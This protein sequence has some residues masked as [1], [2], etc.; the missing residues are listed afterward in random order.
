MGGPCDGGASTNIR[1][2]I[3]RNIHMRCHCTPERPWRNV[4][5]RLLPCAA[6]HISVRGLR[7]TKSHVF[8]QFYHLAFACGRGRF[9]SKRTAPVGLQMFIA[10]GSGIGADAHVAVLTGRGRV[11]LAILTRSPTP[12]EVP[13]VAPRRARAAFCDDLPECCAARGEHRTARAEDRTARGERRAAQTGPLIARAEPPNRTKT[14]VRCPSAAR[15]VSCGNKLP[16]NNFVRHFHPDKMG[17]PVFL[18]AFSLVDHHIRNQ[19]PHIGWD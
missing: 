14:L 12:H 4:I 8:E 3:V 5:S 15:L 17:Q 18:I 2:R 9:A 1:S 16:Q 6:Q 11:S 19:G 7:L 13:Y 10:A